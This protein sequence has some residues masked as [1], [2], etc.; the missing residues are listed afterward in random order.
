MGLRRWPQIP[1]CPASATPGSPPPWGARPPSC[2]S[3]RCALFCAHHWIVALA[4]ARW[5][6]RCS[7]DGVS[8]RLLD[9]RDRCG[10][11]RPAPPRP[12]PAASR[13][14]GGGSGL[15]PRSCPGPCGIPSAW[16][17]APSHGLCRH[18]RLSC[19]VD[20]VALS[21]IFLFVFNKHSLNQS[22]ERNG[23]HT[24]DVSFTGG[25]LCERLLSPIYTEL[26]KVWRGWE[27][28]RMI[29]VLF[30]SPSPSPSC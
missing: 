10:S 7:L 18:K 14:A 24:R 21:T 5:V 13:A 4:R 27:T 3:G 29:L 25:R 17:S 12:L 23:G 16:S 15:G 11:G 2:G 22:K 19:T 8:L 1:G 30:S 9:D 6:R 28:S 26:H 20:T